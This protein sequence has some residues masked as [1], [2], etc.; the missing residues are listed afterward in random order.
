MLKNMSLESLHQV[1]QTMQ[2]GVT[3]RDLEGR[4]LYTNQAEARMHGYTLEELKDRNVTIFAPGPSK[5]TPLTREQ[6]EKVSS[7]RRE[8]IN[9]RKNGE[10]FPV[11]LMSD[12]VRDAEG[13]PVA[14][15]TTCEDITERKAAEIE[16]VQR[17]CAQEL[18]KEQ[19][20]HLMQVI[21]HCPVAIAM[22]DRDLKYMAT[23]AMWK[24][25]F[26]LTEPNLVGLSHCQVLPGLA[27]KWMETHQ[28]ALKGE[29]ISISEDVYVAPN[30]T[31]MYLR[32]NIHPWRSRGGEIGGLLIAVDRINEL[33]EAREV[34]L[35]NVRLKSEFLAMM[36]HEIRTPMNGVIGMVDLLLDTPLS[37]EQKK[38]AQA[39]KHS[40]NSLLIIINDILD[41]SKI[42][43]G[44]MELEETD[45][46][47]EAV[48]RETVELVAPQA[49]EKKID[50]VVDVL[51]RVPA[52][53]KGDPG[54]IGQVILN[55]VG[56]AVKFTHHGKVEIKMSYAAGE[57]SIDVM[58]TGIGLSRESCSKLFVPFTQADGSMARKFGGTGLGLSISKK[59]VELMRGAIGVESE[60]GKGSRFHF[61]LPLE[62]SEKS[63]TPR[64]ETKIDESARSACPDTGISILIA[65]DNPVNQQVA[66]LQLRKLGYRCQAVA[67][68]REA[69]EAIERG[70]F[71][72]VL[73]DCQMPEMDGYEAARAIRKAESRTARR[74][75]I[76]AMTAHAMQ[77]DRERCVAAGMDDYLSKPVSAE[78]LRKMLAQWLKPAPTPI[79]KN[80][81]AQPPVID[82]AV[83]GDLRELQLP[84]EPDVVAEV[85]GIFLGSAAD[86]LRSLKEAAA[87]MDRD[88]M[89]SVA[90]AM[91]SSSGSLGALRLSRTF[92]EL[93][94]QAPHATSLRLQTI[95]R[96]VESAFGEA[97][98]ELRKL[99]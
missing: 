75:P 83:L 4:I 2:I 34:A 43:A 13:N 47:P 10:Q 66:I 7:W 79:P 62:L 81:P 56:N 54:R 49:A 24:T 46:D 48:L 77:K 16:I 57:L 33:V 9:V 68:G 29:I 39:V 19:S 87:K 96:E 20:A 38:Y 50:L 73:M 74:L 99:C 45:F 27:E 22:V 67:N 58:D 5:K 65:E 18:Y 89:A 25:E 88:G 71:G 17:R 90:H 44:K 78:A 91:K 8:S 15:I 64:S 21:T 95:V 98:R 23:S 61:K 55:L 94:E 11:Q 60:L 52:M 31:K 41:F 28:A 30:G 97:E 86:R 59:L 32:W 36:S 69:L 14:L 12:V 53:L 40:G 84:D 35:E 42:E 93:E 3:L 92:K 85:V 63:A 1:L 82:K 70:G 76:I 6:L 26:G 72:L 37:T 51:E 80:A